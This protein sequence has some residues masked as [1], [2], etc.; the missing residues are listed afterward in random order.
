LERPWILKRLQARII[1]HR[2]LGEAVRSG[3]LVGT[4][5]A[6][7]IAPEDIIKLPLHAGN[8]LDPAPFDNRFG[9]IADLPD[10]KACD[11]VPLQKIDPI[12]MFPSGVRDNECPLNLYSVKV[13]DRAIRATAK[14]R[15]NEILVG[16][17]SYSHLNSLWRAHRRPGL[18]PRKIAESGLFDDRSF[19]A[20]SAF[21]ADPE[22]LNVM[23]TDEEP[24]LGCQYLLGFPD[25][26]EFLFLEIPIVEDLSA[27]SA[28]QVVMM[29][30]LVTPFIFEADLAV[31]GVDFP[32]Q[33]RP[34][35]QVERPID[36]RQSNFRICRAKRGVYVLS[37]QVLLTPDQEIEDL[38][39]GHCPPRAMILDL[40]LMLFRSARF[41]G[42]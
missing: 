24:V 2:W 34:V 40:S 32:H 23:F 10:D 42:N 41:H 20:W 13:N 39:P 36:R 31:S 37:T 12:P 16:C 25:E 17:D 3:A 30:R 1:R 6:F 4:E 22:K 7:E 21:L 26:I 27:L 9:I 29:I 8:D 15:R 38:L 11:R 18:V 19:S 35:Q 14:A 33:P 28:D 5:S